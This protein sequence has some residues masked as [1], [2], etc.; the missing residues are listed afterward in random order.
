MSLGDFAGLL[1]LGFF[2]YFA[3]L[4]TVFDALRPRLGQLL[5]YFGYT[6]TPDQLSLMSIGVVTV[7]AIAAFVWIY[8]RFV[9]TFT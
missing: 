1:L 7:I 8:K 3:A 9:P 2:V 4:H 5:E 6:A